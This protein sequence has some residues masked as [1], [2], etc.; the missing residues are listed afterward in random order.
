MKENING[1]FINDIIEAVH[2][3]WEQFLFLLP[4]LTAAIIILIISWFIAY[5]T[6]ALFDKKVNK[7]AKD[8]LLI[9]YLSF[10]FKWIIIII[11]FLLALNTIGLKGVA[12]G[13][14]AGAGISALIFGFAFKDIAENFLAGAILAFDRPFDINDTISIKGNSGVIKTLNLRTTH[15]RTFD[16]QDIFIPNAII[17]KSEVINLTKN[18]FIGHDFKIET[19]NNINITEFKNALNY[20]LLDIKEIHVFKKPFIIAEEIFPEKIIWRVYFWT[21]TLD[22][23]NAFYHLKSKVIE[24]VKEL[25]IKEGYWRS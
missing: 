16:S 19:N 2:L 18:G 8:P 10:V 11:G 5:K 20:G 12:A 15:I 13:I 6:K 24:H 21:E 17:L 9:K 1:R 4:R 14:L 7:N 25:M 22:Y 23:Q 3:Y